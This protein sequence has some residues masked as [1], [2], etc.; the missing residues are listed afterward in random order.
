MLCVKR[1]TA[2]VSLLCHFDLIAGREDSY[3]DVDSYAIWELAF[4]QMKPIDLH[5]AYYT[6]YITLYQ[7]KQSCTITLDVIY[8]KYV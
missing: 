3:L 2:V 4:I 6:L 1:S 7:S 5:I 8:S